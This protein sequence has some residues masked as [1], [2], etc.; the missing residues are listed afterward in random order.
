METTAEPLEAVV[1][2]TGEHV[3]VNYDGILQLYVAVGTFEKFL[4][5][6]IEI[7][8]ECANA[9]NPKHYHMEI[10]PIDF[11]ERNKLGFC[12]GNVIK[13]VSRHRMKN[14]AEDIRKAIQYLSFILKYQY[15]IED[16][17][18]LRHE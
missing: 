14:G 6:D 1:K 18:N 15:G 2:A 4:P 13:Y 10:E 9:V 8:G 17:L 11:I 16:N 5:K 3:A 12:E 7:L